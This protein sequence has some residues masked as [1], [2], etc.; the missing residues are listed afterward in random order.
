MHAKSTNR[1]KKRLAVVAAIG[2][3]CL[4]TAGVYATTLVV[5]ANEDAAGIDA[6]VTCD[7]DGVTV[8]SAEPV[9]SATLAAPTTGGFVIPEVTVAGIDMACNGSTL[10]LT[11]VSN[12]GGNV[13]LGTTLEWTVTGLT[14]DPVADSHTFQA[15]GNTGP[16]QLLGT[17]A[18]ALHK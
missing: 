12:A 11:P 1:N 18:V 6:V 9:Y 13:A 3:A 8:T 7:A 5:T 16:A 10:Y 14:A 4:A 15:L 17:W 2:A